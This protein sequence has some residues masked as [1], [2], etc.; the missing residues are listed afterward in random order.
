MSFLKKM[1]FGNPIEKISPADAYEGCLAGETV[2]I[3]VREANE[4][5]Q[6]GTPKGCHRIAL[7]DVD[8]VEQVAALTDAFPQAALA[9]S[10]KSGMRAE[11]AIKKLRMSNIE[12]LKLVAG[13]FEAWSKERLPI[14]ND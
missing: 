10:C 6:T 11:M 3:D 2:I 5:Q 8:F 13:G 9:I 4:W 1:G 14:S 12:N 7:N